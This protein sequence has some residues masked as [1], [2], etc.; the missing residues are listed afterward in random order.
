MNWSDIGDAMFGGLPDYAE[1]LALVSNSVWAG[2]VLGLVGGLI[3]VFVM[4][5]DMAFAVHGISEL[6]FAGAAAALLV[7]VDVVTGSIVGSL[8]AAA[9]IGVLGAKA[10]DRNSIIGVL[11][12]FGLG[13]GILFLSLYNGRSANRFS[14]LTGQVVSVQNVQLGWLIVICAFVLVA[15]LLIWRPLAFDSLDPQSAAARGVPTVAVSLGFMLLLGLVVAVAVHIIGALLVMSLVV[16]TAAAA[17]RITSGTIALPL[18][19]AA[20]GLVSA[21]GGILLAVMGTLPV[22]PYITTLSFLVYLVCRIA[23][24]RRGRVSRA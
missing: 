1:I 12:P 21:V 20:F 17:A 10:R 3:G 5:R 4:Q 19:S 6:S 14:L 2:A 22:S 16:T 15:L 8:I 24:S 7:G 18:L 9:L 11:M 13:L 23:G